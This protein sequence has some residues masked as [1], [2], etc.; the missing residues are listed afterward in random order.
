MRISGKA[1]LTAG[2]AAAGA[3]TASRIAVARRNKDRETG[4]HHV[5]TVNRAFDEAGTGSLPAP[6]AALGE[7]VE[8]RRQPAPGGRGTEFSARARSG[9]V[10]GG[11]IRRALREARSELE[12]GYVLL[13]GGPTTRPT[14]L[15][16]PLREATAHGREGGL[17]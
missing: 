15:N 17:L 6:L 9:K 12:I 10:S 14:A 2:A 8:I 5:I 13:P 3:V 4:R 7:A 11:E 16:K 1:L